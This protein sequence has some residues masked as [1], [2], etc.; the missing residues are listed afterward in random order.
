MFTGVGGFEVGFERASHNRY[1]AIRFE[2]ISR[3]VS[4]I[5]ERQTRFTCVGFSEIDKYANQLLAKK[6]TE[7]RNY[8]DATKINPAELPDFDILCG[9]FPCQAFSITGKRRGFEDTRGTLFFEIARI[10][11]VKRPS[12]LLLE[13]V[14]GLLNH[15]KG[16]TFRVIIQALSDLGYDIQWMVLNSKFFG[17]PQNRE[18]IFLIGSLRGIPRPEI[19]PFGESS[20]ENSGMEQGEKVISNALDANYGKGNSPSHREDHRMSEINYNPH[21]P[22]VIC[23]ECGGPKHPGSKQCM[24]CHSKRKRGSVGRTLKRHQKEG[25]IKISSQKRGLR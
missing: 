16:E 17:V 3:K 6:W 11:E 7:I 20:K 2:D 13:N 18:R 14:K 24:R 1:E 12:Y 23:Q 25:R 22:G 19:L 8:G 5:K 15:N 10:L 21:K 9:G 4:N